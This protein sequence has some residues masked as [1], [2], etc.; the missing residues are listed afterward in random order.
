MAIIGTT[1]ASTFS[2]VLIVKLIATNDKEESL[3][4]L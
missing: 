2:V 4:L 3:N 1:F